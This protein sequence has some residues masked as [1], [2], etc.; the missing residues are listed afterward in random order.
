MLVLSFRAGPRKMRS[1]SRRRWGALHPVLRGE[2]PR[3]ESLS[4]AEESLALRA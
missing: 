1:A 2:L 3:S 4:S